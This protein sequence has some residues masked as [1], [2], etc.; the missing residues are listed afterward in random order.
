MRE[1]ALW[2]V[3][4]FVRYARQQSIDLRRFPSFVC[5]R[6]YRLFYCVEGWGEM[7]IE[8]TRY[9]VQPGVLV[10]ICPGIPYRYLPDA[11]DPMQLLAFN[12][13][14]DCSACTMTIPIPPKNAEDFTPADCFSAVQVMDAP[15]LNRT[16]VVQNAQPFYE[17]LLEI[18]KEY[19]AGK[20]Y[21]QQRCSGL[22]LA[23]LAQ[24]VYLLDSSSE[25][26]ASVV[27][28]VIEY[29][30]RHYGEDISNGSLGEIFGYHPN[31]LNRLF[32]KHTG[33]S[34]HK[35]L[36]ELRVRKAIELLQE[37]DLSV[38]AVAVTTGFR[39]V[40]HFFRYFKQSTGRKP[41]DF[42]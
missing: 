20:M 16:A 19:T 34:L 10:Y 5:G 18:K 3:R 27:D 39:D 36:Q 35:Y 38:T 40:P 23:V 42:R 17:K 1:I 28:P 9:S 11:Q 21:C 8:N 26:R 15:A 7:E 33:R 2:E 25:G 24:L 32:V 37:T 30:G 13:D 22:L 29:L 6:E 41:S 14:L 12:F 4:P 31:Y